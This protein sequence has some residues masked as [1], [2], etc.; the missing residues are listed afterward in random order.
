MG[1]VSVLLHFHFLRSPPTDREVR[2]YYPS[3]E[4]ETLEV[5]E[6]QEETFPEAFWRSRN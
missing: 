5:I 6:T 4:E 1:L 3:E 2:H